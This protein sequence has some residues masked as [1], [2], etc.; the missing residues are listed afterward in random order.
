MSLKPEGG[1]HVLNINAD[2]LPAFRNQSGR[3][4]E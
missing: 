4:A 3:P 1:V 2:Y